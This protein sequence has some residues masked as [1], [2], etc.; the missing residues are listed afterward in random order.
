MKAGSMIFIGIVVLAALAPSAVAQ[1]ATPRPTVKDPGAGAMPEQTP[2]KMAKPPTRLH[3]VKVQSPDKVSPL[4][5]AECKGIGG[6][7]NIDSYKCPEAGSCSTVDKEGVIRRRCLEK[8][9]EG[10]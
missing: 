7:V 2:A 5:A 4:T 3:D 6:V 8:T 1:S 10:Q 9:V